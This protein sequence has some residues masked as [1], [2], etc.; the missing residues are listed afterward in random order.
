M[1]HDGG[2]TGEGRRTGTVDEGGTRKL[3]VHS[4]RD[5]RRLRSR[6]VKGDGTPGKPQEK[7]PDENEGGGRSGGPC[8]H[9]RGHG[10]VVQNSTTLRRDSVGECRLV[11]SPRWEVG[12]GRGPT[13][14]TPSTGCTPTVVGVG[15]GELTPSQCADVHPWSHVPPPPPPSNDGGYWD[16]EDCN[17]NDFTGQG[18]KVY[19]VLPGDT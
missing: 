8:P 6:C 3:K 16:R 18:V 4:A 2:R 10:T 1:G 15:V 12:R 13:D 5:P 14:M 17:Q 11:S 19:Q 7:C 9:F